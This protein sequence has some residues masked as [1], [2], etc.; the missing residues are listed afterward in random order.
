MADSNARPQIHPDSIFFEEEPFDIRGY[1]I[2]LLAHWKWFVVSLVLCL[3]AAFLFNRY[4][5]PR[6]PV[7]AY[8]LIEDEKSNVTS[9]LLQEMDIY[10]SSSNI[11]NEIGILSSFSLIK[12]TIDSLEY[13]IVY[14]SL[15]RVRDVE[16]YHK[17]LPFRV[18][19]DRAASKMKGQQFRF[20]FLQDGSIEMETQ[21][22]SVAGE[23]KIIRFDEQVDEDGISFRFVKTGTAI[24]GGQEKPILISFLDAEMLAKDWK[25]QISIQTINRDASILELSMESAVPEKARDFLD[26]LIYQYIKAELDDKN[27][28]AVRTISFI[29]DQ[30][31]GI[32]DSLFRTERTLE[33]FRSDNSIV[34]I[35]QEGLSIYNQLQALE[36]EQYNVKLQLEY[37]N[38][39]LQYLNEENPENIVSPSTAGIVDPAL[40]GMVLSLN[41]MTNRRIML[42]ASTSDINPALLTQN[43]QIASTI[44]AIKE[45]VRNLR[46]TTQLK[47]TELEQRIKRAEAD[48]QKLPGNERALVN[49][50][51]R[52]ELNDNLYVYLLEKKAEAGI[53][54]AS[55]VPTTKIVDSA[56][57]FSIVFPKVRRNYLIAALIGL[58]LPVIGLSIKDYF[59]TTLQSIAEVEK[60]VQLPIL[61]S[62]AYSHH[63]TE[64]V[65]DKYP[66]SLVSESFRKMRA[67]LRF[68][69][70][71]EGC[72]KIMFTSFLSGD[73]KTFSALNTAVMMAKA[74]KKTLLLGL[75]MRKPKIYEAL[76]LSNTVG[77][78]NLLVGD[79]SIGEV[80]YPTGVENL[81]FISGGPVP[82][83]PNELLLKDSFTNA[84]KELES[85]FDYIIVDTPP[86]GLVSDALEIG[87][88]MTATI[89][90][91]RHEQTPRQSLDFLNDMTSRNLMTNIGI[92]YNGIDLKKLGNKYGYGYNYGYGYG[93]GQGYYHNE[94]E[95][96]VSDSAFKR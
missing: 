10:R 30:L 95:D 17:N 57:V 58:L 42:E 8:I 22:D 84:L 54:R 70:N 65:L 81:S 55:N 69:E 85:R 60:K 37:F 15:G 96:K 33:Q 28:K 4:A 53:V 16:L 32:R 68:L 62:I 88:Y 13:D 46:N 12:R 35:S 92:L 40:N 44:S 56:M 78:S 24:L 2:K 47:A 23:K 93:Y 34:D 43:R 79:K 27:Q 14:Q 3:A 90:V 91:L 59:T 6:Y 87:K 51:R 38:Y 63:N 52:F 5:T 50:Q 67:G 39:L 45:N 11:E 66:R 61:A 76:G 49:I 72:N 36:T 25:E 86:V 94:E 26:V 80:M 41:D 48:L 71:K 82:P 9:A 64:M 89:F 31:V 75:D 21:S 7:K 29:N 19:V 1:L 77:M 20:E 73:G 18:V 83:N 74:G